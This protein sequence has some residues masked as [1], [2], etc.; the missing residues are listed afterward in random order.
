MVIT[1]RRFS[2]N[3]KVQNP[4]F[5]SVQVFNIIQVLGE[6]LRHFMGYQRDN[7]GDFYGLESP[8][9]ACMCY[10]FLDKKAFIQNFDIA[11]LMLTLLLIN[12]DIQYNLCH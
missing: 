1:N 9:L 2:A 12:K 7:C 6:N 3:L 5:Q 10:S 11:K 8:F 4:L